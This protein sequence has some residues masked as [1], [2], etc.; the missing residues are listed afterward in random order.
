MTAFDECL[1]R[2]SYI[3]GWDWVPSQNPPK[4]HSRCVKYSFTTRFIKNETYHGPRSFIHFDYRN[5][6]Q[7]NERLKHGG[8]AILYLSHRFV[9]ICFVTNN[10][11]C[12]N[13]AVILLRVR[14]LL[15]EELSCEGCNKSLS[16]WESPAPHPTAAVWPLTGPGAPGDSTHI[17]CWYIPEP[18]TEDGTVFIFSL[19][20]DEIWQLTISLSLWWAT[21]LG[22]MKWLMC[23]LSAIE[24]ILAFFFFFFSQCGE[25]VIVECQRCF[26]RDLAS[27]SECVTQITEFPRGDH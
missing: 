25:Y 3:P 27:L 23:C 16:A 7:K 8:R 4:T 21:A 11:A 18:S 6:R 24:L 20:N 13:P 22:Q 26:N 12:W 2:H 5:K 15:W 14:Q 9:T 1:I 19:I 10:S 17:A